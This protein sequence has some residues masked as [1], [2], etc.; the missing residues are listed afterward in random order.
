MLVWLCFIKSWH[1]FM[2][3]CK[4]K[5]E[6]ICCNISNIRLDGVVVM[7]ELYKTGLDI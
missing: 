5:N 7:T 2:C 6:I 3:T 1:T 4:A